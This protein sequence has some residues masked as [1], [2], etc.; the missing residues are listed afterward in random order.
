MDETAESDELLTEDQVARLTSVK[1][2]T[3]RVWRSR[4][5]GPPFVRVGPRTPRYPR[6][7]LR[8]WLRERLSTFVVDVEK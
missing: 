4:R 2:G 1:P 3:L 6:D 5:V 8:K 7:A